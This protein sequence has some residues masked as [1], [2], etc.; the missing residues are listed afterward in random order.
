MLPPP[1]ASAVYELTDHALGLARV[2]AAMAD[3][4]TT[5]LGRP[6]KDDEVRGEWIV[7]GIA[8]TTPVPDVDDATYELHVDGEV[9][10]VDVRD[11]RL[12]PR[13]GA[14]SDPAALITVRA[15]T[16]ADLALGRVDLEAALAEG[17]VTVAGHDA[18][19]R[20]LLASIS[21]SW[22]AIT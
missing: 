5:M 20:H 16:L 6:R 8:V 14:A 18:A 21:R 4:G 12:Q 19:A 2:L 17:H 10:H 1:A 11:G 9:L 22:V 13:Q 7:L 3:W 15:T